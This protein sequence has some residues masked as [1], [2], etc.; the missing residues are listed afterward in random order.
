MKQLITIAVF[1]LL[2]FNPVKGQEWKKLAD[3]F[4]TIPSYARPCPLWFW[5]DSKV[6]KEE[7]I[8]QMHDFKKAGYGGLSILPFGKDFK[9]KYLT[10]EYFDVYR[11]CIEEAQ[12]IGLKLCIYDEY[13]FPSG[14][15]GDIN[16]D[17]V[18]RFKLKYPEFTNK[19]LDKTEYPAKSGNTFTI[20]LPD[21]PL[22]AVVAMDTTN[23]KRIDLI[24]F[25]K[26]G[27][28]TWQVPNG[29]WKVMLFTC[30][31]AGNTVM[32]YLSPEAADL[33]I[34]MTHEE[35]YK[36]FSKYFGNVID[37][38]FFDEPTMYYADGRTWTPDFN[39][40]FEATYGINPALYYPALWYDIG[41]ETAEAR[42]YLFGFR[43]ELYAEG[44]IKKVS[45]WSK[46]H[47]VHATGHQD[48][49]EILNSVGTSGDFMKCF[50]YLDIPG[51][52]KIGGDRPAERFYKLVSSAAY[53]WDHSLVMSE[54]Y[55]AM[56]NIDWHQ[57]FGIAMDQYV[58]GINMLIPHA[59]WYNT[60]K[61]VFKP[62]L[63][64]RNPIY[65][66]SIPI[67]T[68]Y[69]SRLNILMKNDAR[70]KG[71]IAVLYP[72]HTQQSGHYMDG[73]LGHYKGGVEIPDLDYVNVGV[74]LFDS[75]G[76]DHMFLHP[77]VL[78]EQCMIEK[79]KLKLN[80][81]IQY[82]S[83]SHLVI[84]ACKTISMSN[85]EMIKQFADAGGIVIF[86][87]HLP[88]TG[89]LNADTEK[90]KRMTNDLIKKKNVH[91]IENPTVGNLQQVMNK[92]Q[93]RYA[94]NFTGTPVRN[95]HKILYG[96]NIW[97]LANPD[98]KDITTEFELK[99]KYNLEI[100]DPHSGTISKN[101]EE[102][103]SVNGKTSVKVNLPACRSL[104]LIEK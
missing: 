51:I 86:T 34:G 63:S 90:V 12:K 50:K 16:G 55:G 89:T 97:F 17:G 71:D 49:E 60:E 39:K 5:N 66:D 25:V 21:D 67:L 84:P 45:E 11:T 64:L 54:T 73:P 68:D 29:S 80:N 35:Y 40:K 96:K 53:N 44:Y 15:A 37:G 82:N 78:D 104:F 57:I 103:K 48:N 76:Y 56:G 4:Q 70:W 46:K 59:V 94:M 6:E 33:Y 93:D 62:E 83:F 79:G 52:D 2:T 28:L 30:V 43:S 98:K 18:G 10:E 36:R 85:L 95:M 99:G 1:T 26:N 91:F 88:V 61:V 77:D 65:A 31:N 20:K 27:N 23:L 100:W 7:L 81:R 32:D 42:N 58:K 22:M 92:Y 47:G 74:N 69:L 8:R 19:R 14:T 3:D 41:E 87:T 24:E 102:I 38:T 13:G 9:P 101:P 72:I 75:L